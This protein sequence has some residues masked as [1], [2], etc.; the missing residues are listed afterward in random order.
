MTARRE[1]P[2]MRAREHG[3]VRTDVPPRPVGHLARRVDGHGVRHPQ[4]PEHLGGQILRERPPAHHFHQP[5]RDEVVGVVIPVPAAGIGG[6]RR[7]SH[8]CDGLL[9]R[10]RLCPREI[11][12]RGVVHPGGLRQQLPHRDPPIPPVGHDELRQ[13]PDDGPVQLHL[14]RLD[15]LHDGQRGHR[16]RQRGD[17]HRRPLGHVRPG[18][19]VPVPGRAHHPPAVRHGDHGPRQP[20]LLHVL[21]DEPV[22]GSRVQ[23]STGRSW[24]G[25]RDSRYGTDDKR[26]RQPD[27][28]RDGAEN[29][30]QLHAAQ[31]TARHPS[32]TRARTRVPKVVNALLSRPRRLARFDGCDTGPPG[33][34]W[35]RTR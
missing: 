1:P 17:R 28:R 31:C 34:R 32:G 26:T 4:R 16:L 21:L 3:A 29:R 2:R 18:S 33:R 7:S 25:S 27:H 5:C 10:V 20:G 8:R 30:G 6:E 22:D 19:G 9:Q 11:R 14:A 23:H 35:A 24:R 12:I 13:V 15:E